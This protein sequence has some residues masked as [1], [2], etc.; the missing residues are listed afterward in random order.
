[1][2]RAVYEGVAYA[3][4]DCFAATELDFESVRLVGGGARSAFWRQMIS[5]VLNRPVEVPEG[6]EFG[7]KGAALLAGTAIGWYRSIIDASSVTC[8]ILHRHEPAGDGRYDTGFALYRTYA[9]ALARAAPD[10]GSKS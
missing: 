5:D 10:Q 3:I 9:G 8:R 6:R 2:L 1:M 4:R 7:A